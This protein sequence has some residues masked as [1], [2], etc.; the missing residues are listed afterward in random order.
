LQVR[1]GLGNRGLGQDSIVVRKLVDGWLGRRSGIELAP[2]SRIQAAPRFA[3]CPA[4]LTFHLAFG[5]APEAELKKF[6]PLKPRMGAFVRFIE[7][8]A[9]DAPDFT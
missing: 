4:Y 2:S 6:R 5:G 1:R 9:V 8:G 3:R 7:A